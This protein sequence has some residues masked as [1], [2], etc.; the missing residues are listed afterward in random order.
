MVYF[1][2]KH[3]QATVNNSHAKAQGSRHVCLPVGAVE[4]EHPSEAAEEHPVRVRAHLHGYTGSQHD[5]HCTHT[6]TQK[7]QRVKK[8]FR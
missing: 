1:N 4:H 6:H 8:G 7:Q 2:K 3:K 5:K